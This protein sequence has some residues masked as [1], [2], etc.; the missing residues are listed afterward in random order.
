MLALALLLVA[1]L[2]VTV[3]VAVV[4]PGLVAGALM[5]ELGSALLVLGSSDEDVLV[6]V[7]T[8]A[9]TAAARLVR[10]AALNTSRRLAGADGASGAGPSDPSAMLK[11]AGGYA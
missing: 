2:G 7:Y 10:F 4:V 1:G 3:F 9:A 8:K 6:G 11:C 5:S